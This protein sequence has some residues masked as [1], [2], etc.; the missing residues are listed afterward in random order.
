MVRSIFDTLM[1]VGR[2]TPGAATV[3]AA[4]LLWVVVALLVLGPS[5]PEA[6]AAGKPDLVVSQLSNPPSPLEPG[7]KFRA[8]S[9]TKNAGQAKAAASTTRFYL[10]GDKLKGTGDVRF[11]SGQPVG[12]L[13]VGDSARSTTT[14]TVPAAMKPERSYYLIACADDPKEVAESRETNNCRTS[15][16]RVFVTENPFK[17]APEFD[18]TPNPLTVTPTLQDERAVAKTIPT[19]GGTISATASDGTKFALSLP[20]GSLLSEQKITMTPV[21]QVGGLPMSGGLVAGVDLK[22]DGLQL[23]KP[24]RLT[25]TP[26]AGAEV[27][28][29]RQTG[30]SYHGGGEEF[31]LYAL[32]GTEQLAFELSHFSA[33]GVGS[34]TDSERAASYE[35]DAHAHGRPVPPGHLRAPER[36]AGGAAKRRAGRPQ[37]RGEAGRFPRR[38]LP[39]RGEAQDARRRDQRRPG[40]KRDP[41]GSRL[42]A[43]G[44]AIGLGPGSLLRR[45]DR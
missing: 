40:P 28:L 14:L 25:I 37:A 21:G 12:T 44:R 30:F 19:G 33:Y 27:P 4:A 43:T 13:G 11:A 1:W 5:A 6:S 9:T 22:P 16:E 29:S 2:A 23:H 45:Q 32:K 42:G 41:G 17:T 18:F 36:G 38:L 34:A 35:E 24:A 31:H 8:T 10:S 20:A 26:P 39:G 3:V 7:Q 15:A